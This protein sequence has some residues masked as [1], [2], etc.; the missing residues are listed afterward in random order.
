VKNAGNVWIVPDIFNFDAVVDYG[1]R[2]L[3]GICVQ[4]R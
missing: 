1:V 4:S 3:P 2:I